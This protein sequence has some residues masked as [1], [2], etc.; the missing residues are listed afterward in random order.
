MKK[1]IFMATVLL[2]SVTAASYAKNVVTVT[3][4]CGKTAHIDTERTTIENTMKQVIEI[5][6]A[7]CDD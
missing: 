5:D 6:K 4:S 2:F 7:L 3:T 1:K